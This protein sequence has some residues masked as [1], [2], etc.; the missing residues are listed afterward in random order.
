M[1]KCVL[2]KEKVSAKCI[3]QILGIPVEKSNE[4]L[5][6]EP[7]QTRQPFTAGDVWL[8]CI[9]NI[10]FHFHFVSICLYFS[11]HFCWLNLFSTAIVIYCRVQH[12]FSKSTEVLKTWKI[13]FALIILKRRSSFHNFRESLYPMTY[14]VVLSTAIS[15]AHTCTVYSTCTMYN[16]LHVKWVF[17]SI[18]QASKDF[19]WNLNHHFSGVFFSQGRKKDCRKEEDHTWLYYGSIVSWHYQHSLIIIY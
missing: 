15:L 2:E 9:E 5:R 12:F 3:Y 14:I 4:Y 6:P 11:R 16:M 19:T 7:N 17:W 13:V 1:Q 18:I 8:L 10:G